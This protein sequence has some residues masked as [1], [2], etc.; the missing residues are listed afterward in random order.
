MLTNV[1][2]VLGSS[3]L[4]PA[5]QGE[6]FWER[7]VRHALFP[8]CSEDYIEQAL[9][10]AFSDLPKGIGVV[11]I[12]SR[13][14]WKPSHLFLQCGIQ[15]LLWN[16]M[17][18]IRSFLTDAVG[19]IFKWKQRR[20]RFLFCEVFRWLLTDPVWPILHRFS[21]F[22]L[23]PQALGRLVHWKGWCRKRKFPSASITV[24]NSE[25]NIFFM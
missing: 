2:R 1:S 3:E 17:K 8:P 5:V 25:K 23:C 12:Q 9:G 15:G 7:I 20:L 10:I 13:R 16:L 14:C 4:F 18:S 6:F 21:S 22:L 11:D 19:C 24:T